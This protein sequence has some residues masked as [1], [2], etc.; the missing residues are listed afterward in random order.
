MGLE[1]LEVG[2]VFILR[3]IG[4]PGC[5]LNKDDGGVVETREKKQTN[6]SMKRSL[7]Q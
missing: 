5:F 7:H 6:V 4:L 3:V 2:A 1:D